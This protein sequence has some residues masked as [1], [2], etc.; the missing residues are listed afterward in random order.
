MP[1]RS[2]F[3][4][5]EN[6]FNRINEELEQLSGQSPM[7]GF[8][9]DI[10]V[11]VAETDDEIVVVADLPGFSSEDIDVNVTR[12]ELTLSAEH[13]DEH[14]EESGPGSGR[15]YHRQERTRR[16][17]TR[18]IRLPADVVAEDADAT[19]NNGVLTVTLPKQTQGGEEGTHI[20]VE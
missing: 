12:R 9:D 20:D 7:R 8:G 15:R 18:R 17:T 3:D 2:P 6:M 13:E 14:E 4:E 16:H 19:Y 5:I 10:N 11:D 1:G